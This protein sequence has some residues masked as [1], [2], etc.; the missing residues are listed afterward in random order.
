M[1]RLSRRS[2]IVG[3]ALLM[4]SGCMILRG[5]DRAG[6]TELRSAEIASGTPPLAAFV[7]RVA[8]TDLSLAPKEAEI[9]S[10]LVRDAERWTRSIDDARAV[11]IE[12]LVRSLNAGRFVPESEAAADRVVAATEASGPWFDEALAKLHAALDPLQRRALVGRVRARFDGWSRDWS[13]GV[14]SEHAWLATLE[15]D[16]VTGASEDAR[17]TARHWADG[18]L[19]AVR[20]N[21]ARGDDDE[22]AE[23]V[24]RL[25]RFAPK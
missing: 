3:A 12:D 15:T 4:A 17:A 6:T 9:A 24:R 23:L 22:R 18:L 1:V 16:A 7:L 8:L 13:G 11:L 19:G 25:R 14:A 20:D 10:G 2:T 21:L 5:T